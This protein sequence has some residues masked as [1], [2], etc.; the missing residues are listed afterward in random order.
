M[1]RPKKVKRAYHRKVVQQADAP[2]EEK[3]CDEAEDI[4]LAT[5]AGAEIPCLE[6]KEIE[7]LSTKEVKPF[8]K[9]NE[10]FFNI[11]QGRIELEEAERLAKENAKKLAEELIEKNRKDSSNKPKLVCQFC[12]H[13]QYSLNSKDVTAAWC[14]VC[15]RCFQ[16]KWQ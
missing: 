5:D 13:V 2:V 16:A 15:G 10:T 4:F 6:E 3:P 8:K 7:G 1:G 14:E 11:E 12:Q 9:Q